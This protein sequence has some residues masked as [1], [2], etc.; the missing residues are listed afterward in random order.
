[1]LKVYQGKIIKR[2]LTKEEFQ[3]LNKKY[4]R[5]SNMKAYLI[6]ATSKEKKVL[7]LY[8]KQKISL[9]GVRDMLKIPLGSA[10]NKI[11]T[12][13]LKVSAEKYQSLKRS[14]LNQTKL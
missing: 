14:Q 13:A 6:P 10:G 4:I 2:V 12:I 8:L 11:R 7:D 9:T 1:M 3:E 5:V